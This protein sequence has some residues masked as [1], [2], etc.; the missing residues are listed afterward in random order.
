[1]FNPL[2]STYSD[3]KIGLGPAELADKSDISS[4]SNLREAL[5]A[6]VELL[7]K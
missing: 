1:M 3:N 4:G 6:E 5:S 2:V 7:A